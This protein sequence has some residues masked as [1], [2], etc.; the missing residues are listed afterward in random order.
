M[1]LMTGDG[2]ATNTTNALPASSSKFSF[3]SARSGGAISVNMD[4]E[5]SITL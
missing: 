2:R 5:I 1:D 3:N 4:R